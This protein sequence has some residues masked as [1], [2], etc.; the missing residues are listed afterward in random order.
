ME[1]GDTT[2]IWLVTSDRSYWEYRPTHLLYARAIERARENGQSAVDL[3]RSRSGSSVQGFKAQFG[4]LSYPL[5]SFVAPPHRTPRASLE[6]YGR[7]AGIAERVAPIIT[8]RSVGPRL[9]RRIHE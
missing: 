7:V 6:A 5:V 1:W 8:H 2:V 4:G 3:G 9:K